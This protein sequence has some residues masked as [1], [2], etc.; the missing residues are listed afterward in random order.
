MVEARKKEV[1][2][3]DVDPEN[4]PELPPSDSRP[5]HEPAPADPVAEQVAPR[6]AEPSVAPEPV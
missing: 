4:F 6:P 2:S 5:P 3:E 1:E